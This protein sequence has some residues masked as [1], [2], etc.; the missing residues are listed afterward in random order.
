MPA[1][2][3]Q[4]APA[5]VAP[6]VRV[7]RAAEVTVLVAGLRYTG[8]TAAWTGAAVEAMTEC[9]RDHRGTVV[10]T[11]GEALLAMWGAPVPSL[12]HAPLA[13][14]AARAVVARLR[15]L[16]NRW[17]PQGGGPLVVGIG[18]HS[19]RARVGNT[20]SRRRFKY[21][22][23]GPTVHAAG[24][25]AAATAV[26][27]A[28]VIL[29]AAT[30]ARLGSGFAVRRLGKAALSRG[31]APTELYELPD[32]DANWPALCG[33]YEKALGEFERRD[34]RAAARTLGNFLLEQPGDGPSLALLSRAAHCLAHETPPSDVVWQ[35]AG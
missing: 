8:G 32:D 22:P 10:D 2:Q 4:L 16:E 18:L 6:G 15:E 30:Q 5:L 3:T 27:P 34:Y 9:V 28:R 14:R 21:G 24:R 20:T 19:G 11:N 26:V 17:R 13:C 29:T 12:D 25:V 7:S 23:S 35:L 31:T 1:L 33:A